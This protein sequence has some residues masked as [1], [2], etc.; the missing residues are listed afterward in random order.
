M[1]REL[2]VLNLI[3]L[4]FI[5]KKTKPEICMGVVLGQEVPLQAHAD[6]SS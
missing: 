6:I 1:D 5:K 4:C 3:V 2:R